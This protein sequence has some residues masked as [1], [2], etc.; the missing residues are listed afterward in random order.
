MAHCIHFLLTLIEKYI[1]KRR[2]AVSMMVILM[3]STAIATQDS[4]VVPTFIKPYLISY[5]YKHNYQ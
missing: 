5:N 3:K 1:Q 4:H 2:I